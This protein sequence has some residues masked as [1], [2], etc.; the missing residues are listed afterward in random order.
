MY[1][2]DS[3]SGIIRF[4]YS[5]FVLLNFLYKGEGVVLLGCSEKLYGE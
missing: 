2:A 3:H 1:S 4:I 5:K